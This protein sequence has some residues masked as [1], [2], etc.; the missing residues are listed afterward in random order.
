MRH[1]VSKDFRVC[2]NCQRTSTPISTP[3]DSFTVQALAT[4]SLVSWSS[5][6]INDSHQS[7]GL[8]I[9]GTAHLGPMLYDRS[10]A[11]VGTCW[12]GLE[13]QTISGLEPMTL[14]IQLPI[15]PLITEVALCKLRIASEASLLQDGAEPGP[16]AYPIFRRGYLP[17]CSALCQMPHCY[18]SSFLRTPG[19]VGSPL[20]STQ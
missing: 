15:W 3:R 9:Q 4:F 14:H 17:L 5:C 1:P 19:H 12:T 18:K 10:V 7:H 20:A 2:L 6:A 16:S 13:I 8:L 11:H